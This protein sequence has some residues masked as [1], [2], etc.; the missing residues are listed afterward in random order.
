M[1]KIIIFLTFLFVSLISFSSMDI[2]LKVGDK[3][4][5][6]KYYTLEGKELNSKDLLG[7]KI[8][9]NFSAT[10][11][12]QC[13]DEKVKLNKDYPSIIKNDNNLTFLVFFGPYGRRIERRDTVEAV[14]NYM[15]SKD[16]IFPSYFD[17]NREVIEFFGVKSIP[18][19]FLIDEKGIIVEI[20]E[21]YYKA[22]HLPTT[23]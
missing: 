3:V 5:N 19:S 21:E 20:S 16:Y 22:L 8:L 10:W 6:F 17:K 11:C 15:T 14:K 4:P 23:K 7:K 2:P 13:L 18:T 1:K 12:P 9:L